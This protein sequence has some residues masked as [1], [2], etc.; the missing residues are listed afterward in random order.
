M[1]LPNNKEEF[2]ELDGLVTYNKKQ[3]ENDFL[4]ILTSNIVIHAK[5][6]RFLTINMIMF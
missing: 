6:K 1:E 2:L 4:K 5:K 3:W